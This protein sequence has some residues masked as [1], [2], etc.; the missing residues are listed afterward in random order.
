MEDPYLW[1]EEID[2]SDA[3]NWVRQ[4][5]DTTTA[6]FRTDE[7]TELEHRIRQA[8]DTDTRIPYVRRRGNYLYNFWRDATNPRGLWRRTTLD[9]YRNEA[10]TWEVL[11]DVD[12]LAEAEDENWV[13]AGATVRHPQ[14]DRALISLSRGGSD[15]TVVREFDLQTQQFDAAGFTLPEAKSDITWIDRNTVFVGTDFGDGTLTTSGYPRTVRRW[16][17]GTPLGDAELVFEGDSTD[18]AVGASHDTAEGFERSFVERAIDFYHAEHYLLTD[19]GTIR[20]DVPDDA[21][22]SV[23]HAWLLVRLRSPWTVGGVEYPAGSL[24]RA[25][26]ENFLGGDHTVTPVFTPDEQT[27]LLQMSW[28]SNFLVLVTMTDVRTAVRIINP[29]D[30]ADTTVDDLPPLQSVTITATDDDSDEVFITSSGY[31]TPA[32]LWHGTIEEPGTIALHD[33]KKSPELFD[34]NAVVTTQHFATSADGTRIPYFEVRSPHDTPGPALLY[35]YGGFENSL[36]PG[37]SPGVGLGWIERGGTFVV[38]NIRGGGEYGPNWHTQALRE[39]RPR[40][41]E[42]FAAVAQDLISRGVTT[43]KMLGAQGGSNGGLLMGVMLTRYPELFGAI[44]CQVP[45]L[46]MK[47]YHLL[48]AGASWK[49]EYGDPDDPNDWEF[50]K[51][52]S[53]YHNTS[54]DQV[55]PPALIMTSTR[56][57]RVHPGHA[58]KMTALLEQQGHPVHYYEN[59][60][61]GHSGAADNAQL[62]F[63]TALAYQYLWTQLNSDNS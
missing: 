62:A 17:R 56:D 27:S 25:N 6:A 59:I 48:L 61:G 13:W 8:L 50:L 40:A 46:D 15:A 11:I 44:I 63:K 14:F 4:H 31:T 20:I 52:Y 2:G 7:F 38:A 10:P 5:N 34:A 33:I 55:Y 23:H 9:E 45:L 42:D 47:R 53:P 24:L 37:Y 58:R 51:Q 54:E 28:T 18:V 1:L 16:K 39:N 30:W 43:A 12:A 26:F 35:G 29:T 21:Q 22:I 57:D 19:A 49:A 41:Y 36:V 32:T 3:L 60:E